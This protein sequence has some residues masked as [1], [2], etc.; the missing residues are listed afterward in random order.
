MKTGSRMTNDAKTVAHG[1]DRAFY[2]KQF[3]IWTVG[4]LLGLLSLLMVFQRAA[5]FFDARAYPAPGAFYDLGDVILHMSCLG[6]GPVTV[7][8]SSGMGNPA[9]SWRPLE[10]LLETEYRVCS[11]DRDGLG[12]SGDSARPRDAALAADRLARLLDKAQI[13]GPIILVGHSYGALVAR[14]FV[15]AHPN[16]VDALVMLDSSHEDMGERFPPFA[17]EGFRDLLAGFQLAPWLNAVALPRL[18]GLFAP[19]IDGLEGE[20]RSRSLALLNSIHH[21]SGTAEEAAGWVRSAVAARAV[22]DNGFGSLPLDVFVAGDWP[23]E[24]MPSWLAMQDELSR[25]SS[26]RRF[27]V[28]E[29]ANHPQIGMDARYIALVAQAIREQA[30]M[31]TRS[32]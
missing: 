11:Y 26:K 25:L 13:T 23:E 17:Q 16:R 7:L 22:R 15:A 8:F 18:L 6:D 27:Q 4:G 30:E 31:L 12:W 5:E 29:E 9:A 21:M 3:G 2:L 28:L 32:P 10:R 24:M 1:G 19:A 20:D 14:V